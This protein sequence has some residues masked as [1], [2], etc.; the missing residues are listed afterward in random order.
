MSRIYYRGAKAAV[1]CYDI[2]NRPSWDKADFWI[3]E[4]RRIEEVKH[5]YGSQ[6][7]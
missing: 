5:L 4:L 7:Q 2:T 6:T 3:N 1:V